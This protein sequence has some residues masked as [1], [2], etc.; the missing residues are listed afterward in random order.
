MASYYKCHVTRA[1]TDLSSWMLAL[2]R[3]RNPECEHVPGKMWTVWLGRLF[4]A[5][6]YQMTE[7]NLWR[8]MKTGFVHCRPR[9]VVLFAPDAVRE[10]FAPGAGHSGHDGDGRA[11]RHLAWTWYPDP[12]DTAYL[13][14]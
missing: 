2:S 11:L 10:T 13:V 1:L 6:L 9:A 4:D 12:A 3:N 14:D 5:V 7:D 8:A